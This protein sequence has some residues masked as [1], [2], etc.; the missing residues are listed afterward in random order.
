MQRR[1]FLGEVSGGCTFLGELLANLASLHR[2]S[3]PSIT[4]TERL[5]S[6]NLLH[7]PR[8]LTCKLRQRGRDY[9]GHCPAQS[10]GIDPSLQSPHCGGR[11]VTGE[12]ETSH[13]CLKEG[14]RSPIGQA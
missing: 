13:R 1:P 5:R 7:M 4:E 14:N 8:G 2:G 10:P 12:L 9:G 11:Y 3:A 6:A